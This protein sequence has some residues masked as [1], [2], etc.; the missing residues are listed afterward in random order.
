MSKTCN[1][2]CALNPAENEKN[3]IAMDMIREY[4]RKL[5][6][7]SILC[8]AMFALWIVSVWCF[9]W[10]I[11]KNNCAS[12]DVVA[13]YKN[14]ST[15]CEIKLTNR[16]TPDKNKKRKNDTVKLRLVAREIR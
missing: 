3:S 1:G 12:E 13:E 15:E 4:H 5:K 8:L 16:S 6:L 2:C 10:Y 11:A 9:S 7:R 14:V